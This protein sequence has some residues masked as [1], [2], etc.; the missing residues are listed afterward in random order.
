MSPTG[1]L[2]PFLMVQILWLLTC[3]KQGSLSP[4]FCEYGVVVGADRGDLRCR[5]VVG[6]SMAH[7]ER[8]LSWRGGK[9][10][11]WCLHSSVVL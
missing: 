10:A 11:G 6:V 5:G 7:P 2:S 4:A 9:S 3:K 1:S 8:G